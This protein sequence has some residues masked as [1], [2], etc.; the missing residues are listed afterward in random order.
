V[1]TIFLPWRLFCWALCSAVFVFVSPAGASA[2]QFQAAAE[3][4]LIADGFVSPISVEEINDGSGR[5]LIADQIGV[6]QVLTREGKLLEEPFLDLRDRLSEI[7]QGFDERGLLGLAL[8]PEFPENGKFYVYY[9]APLRPNGPDK[10]NHTS[11]V[12]E[13]KISSGDKN[14]ADAAS[15]RVLLQIDQPQFNHNSGRVVFGPDGYLYIGSGDGG[16][17]NDVGLG[18]PPEGNGQ[19]LQTLLGKI[20]R[21][22]V[23]HGDPYAIPGDNPFRNGPGLPEI[24]A[25]GLR[26]PW[27]MTFDRGGTRQ[28]FVADVG[29]DAFEE[30]N[31][32]E[33]GGNYGWNIRE[34]FHCFDPKSPTDPP[35]D[36][37]RTGARGEPLLDPILDYKNLKAHRQD[38]EGISV[39]GGYVYRGKA[40]PELQ[41]R[42]VFADWS[43]YWPKAEGVF[44]V[45]SYEN[46]KWSRQ[47]LSLASHPKATIRAYI[48][49]FGEDAQGELYIMT[50]D[51]NSLIG[52]NGRVYK[53]A[54]VN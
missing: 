4:K 22:D 13:F 35:E 8:H 28:F 42:Y 12:S 44:F 43:R 1:K 38:G 30:V 17:A 51:T 26:N 53:L 46:G 20:L 37:P 5:L 11:H 24:Y 29:Q 21:I 25:Y 39:T 49:S 40:I 48:L 32:I 2:A 16:G 52:R 50:N 14:K 27:G 7:N 3:L 9:S 45:A 54:P 31:I 36:C 41:G 18:H 15:E 33:R 47:E 23:N 6:I 19:H 10:W 34:G